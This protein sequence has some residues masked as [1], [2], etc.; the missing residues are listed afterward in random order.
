MTEVLRTAVA[1]Y[2]RLTRK[3]CSPSHRHGVRDLSSVICQHRNECWQAA[4]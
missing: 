4:N 2:A 3:S 1:L